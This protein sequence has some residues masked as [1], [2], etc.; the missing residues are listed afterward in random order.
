MTEAMT[1][2]MT[3][4]MTDCAI[5][6]ERVAVLQRLA[7]SALR[8]WGKEAREIRLLKMREN[9]VFKVVDAHGESFA[10][11]V[12]RQGYHA[13]DALRSELQWIS[14]LRGSGIDVPVP[15]PT[16]D[17][18]LFVM[19]RVDGLPA[20]HQVDMFEWI[21]GRALGTSEG[22]L[23]ND[24]ADV[25]RTYH[26]VGSL[27]ARLH[28]QAS[29]WVLPEGFRRHSWD[30]DGLVGEQPFWG[31]FWELEALTS[32]ER[33]LLIRA[34]DQVRSE[35]RALTGESDLY[36][37]FGL[38]H[39]DLVPENLLQSAQGEL[40]LIDFDDAGFGWHLFELATA[41]YFVQEDPHY[42]VVKAS[43]V[44]GY[45]AHRELPDSLLDK[46]PVFMAARGFTYLGWAHTRPTTADGL[47]I[48]PYVI[49]LACLQARRLLSRTVSPDPPA[50]R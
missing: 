32:S 28:N 27:A 20:P 50:P 7:S 11:R 25:E 37:N 38:I 39:A 41:L 9:A 14:A 22:G 35:L 36:R 44:E 34:R 42:E 10:M 3:E 1:E 6:S 45:R 23:R 26:D 29:E 8:C 17:G 49:R 43:L 47:A 46:L 13:D 16:L 31:R 21:E 4:T 48:L 30:L 19:A 18:R 12:H 24:I 2:A 33:E 40:R 15:V 5:D